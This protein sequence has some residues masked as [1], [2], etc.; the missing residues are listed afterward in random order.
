MNKS[1]KMLISVIIPVYNVENYLRRCLDSV[2]NQTYKNLEII[3]V[4]DGSTDGSAAICD[5]YLLK[6]NRIKV[7]HKENG[8]QSSAR[9]F[10]LDIMQGEYICFIDADDLIHIDMIKDLYD[11]AV[12]NDADMSLC[13]IREFDEKNIPDYLKRQTVECKVVDRNNAL[14]MYD[15]K[16]GIIMSSPCNKLYQKSVFENIRFPL[17]RKL[18]DLA[19][20]YKVYFNCKKIAVLS[21]VYYYYFMRINSTM[22]SA[23]RP[24]DEAVLGFDEFIQYCNENIKEEEF[25][26]RMVTMLLKRKADTILEDYYYSVKRKTDKSVL[27]H[28]EDIYYNMRSQLKENGVLRPQYRIFEL[29]PRLFCVCVDVYYRLI[30]R[31]RI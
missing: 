4:D 24:T 1:E 11:C 30:G 27:K 13:G 18:E 23:K 5:E 10:A 2:L 9:N 15:G 25:K 28:I 14:L 3:L 17:K 19:T 29:N 31:S 26:N 7:F 21:N 12:S 16:Y 22:H 20:I 8:G 6:D